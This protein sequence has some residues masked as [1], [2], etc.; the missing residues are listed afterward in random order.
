MYEDESLTWSPERGQYETASVTAYHQRK[1]FG[2]QQQYAATYPTVTK[3]MGS[4]GRPEIEEEEVPEGGYEIPIPD[5]EDEEEDEYEMPQEEWLSGE[6]TKPYLDDED[7]DYETL[8]K[9]GRP[10]HQLI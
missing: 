8:E 3:G 2:G 6:I 10:L 4:D 9:S 7:S 1:A 5:D